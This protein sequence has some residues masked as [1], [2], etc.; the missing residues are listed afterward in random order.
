MKSLAVNR[1]YKPYVK[2]M[3]YYIE[4]IK[5]RNYFALSTEEMNKATLTDFYATIEWLLERGY[6]EYHEEY[7][8]TI[9]P[10]QQNL[11]VALRSYRV[12]RNGHYKSVKIFQQVFGGCIITE[13]DL[14]NEWQM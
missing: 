6:D 13:C 14:K 7:S 2:T 9:N 4:P 3:Y 12:K 8:N 1:K 5:K 10:V 11:F